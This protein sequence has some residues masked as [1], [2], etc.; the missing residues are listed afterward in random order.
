M[1]FK[2]PFRGGSRAVNG[3]TYSDKGVP[4]ARLPVMDEAGGASVE[5]VEFI[6]AMARWTSSI[7]IVTAEEGGVRYGRTVTAMMPLAPQPP[8]LLVSIMRDA[9]LAEVIE[10]TEG[11]SLSMLAAGQAEVADA[12]AG[13]VPPPQRFE[14][15]DWTQWPSGR[16]RLGQASVALDCRLSGVIDT[17]SHLVFSGTITCTALTEDYAPLLWGARSY[18]QVS[19]D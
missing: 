5:Q 7:W 6:E 15:G 9:L 13:K 1:A 12:F 11:F 18:R 2:F 14:R 4:R 8:T 17:E 3:A 10:R 19:D 16:P